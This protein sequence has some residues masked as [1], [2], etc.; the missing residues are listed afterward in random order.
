MSRFRSIATALLVLSAAAAAQQRSS[1]LHDV[2]RVADKVVRETDPAVRITTARDE[3]GI[4]TLIWNTMAGSLHNEGLAVTVLSVPADT[5]VTLA[6]AHPAPLRIVLNGECVYDRPQRSGW[7]EYDYD[8]YQFPS[9][10]SVPLKAGMDTMLVW[11]SQQGSDTAVL[12]AVIAA[13][14]TLVPY[15]RWNAP[16]QTG[17]SVKEAVAALAVTS[18]RIAGREQEWFRRNFGNNREG[19]Q[20]SLLSSRPSRRGTVPPDASFRQHPYSEWHY[21]NGQM[22]HALQKLSDVSHDLRYAVLARQYAAAA[23]SSWQEHRAAYYNGTDRRGINYRLSRMSV[24]DDGGAAALPLI[25]EA[26]HRT[27]HDRSPVVAAVAELLRNGIPR[28]PD[29]TFCRMDPAPNTVWADDLFMSV[30]FLLRYAEWTGEPS[31]ID[32]A[33][34]QVERFYAH[35]TEPGSGLVSHGFYADSSRRS[36]IAWGRANGWMLWALTE[37]L[38]KVPADHPRSAALHLLFEKHIIAIVRRQDADGMWHQVIDHPETYEETSCTA[39]FTLALA[40][41]VRLGWIGPQYRVAA[42]KGWNALRS[43]IAEDG[44]VSGICQGTGIGMSVEYY[45]RRKVLPHDPRGLGAVIT[46]GIEMERMVETSEG[47]HYDR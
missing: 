20:W 39:I 38:L 26:L 12:C 2:L 22:M 36:G 45:Q 30:P 19:T 32:S 16:A 8:R 14:A 18:D 41:G 3:D 35:L 9:V 4:H 27:T 6:L 47:K 34:G 15:G 29:G 43:R 40:R 46:A 33:I 37:T 13:N 31:L 17:L 24:L 1:P 44:T 23:E 11:T 10:V 5:V 25:E 21:A 28:L 7:K 42:E